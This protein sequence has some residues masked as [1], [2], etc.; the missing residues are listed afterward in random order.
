MCHTNTVRMSRIRKRVAASGERVDPDG[1]STVTRRTGEVVWARRPSA[2]DPGLCGE[3]TED[4]SRRESAMRAGGSSQNALDDPGWLCQLLV[5]EHSEPEPG[6]G[7]SMAAPP[8]RRP[9]KG[10]RAAAAFAAAPAG[11]ARVHARGDADGRHPAIRPPSTEHLLPTDD[12]FDWPDVLVRIAAEEV[13]D[14]NFDE[15]RFPDSVADASAAPRRGD[16]RFGG[17]TETTAGTPSP[18]FG[19]R[20]LAFPTV[21]VYGLGGDGDGGFTLEHARYVRSALEVLSDEEASP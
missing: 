7:A 21:P 9:A 5:P 8:R 18:P 2:S 14:G 16:G 4:S 12:V 15:T 1:G 19:A 3:V 17:V 13:G 6:G 10:A 20:A 11:G